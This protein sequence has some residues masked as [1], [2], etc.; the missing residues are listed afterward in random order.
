MA[1]FSDIDRQL[2][3]QC[4]NRKLDAKALRNLIPTELERLVTKVERRGNALYDPR[5][6]DTELAEFLLDLHGPDLLRSR[7]VREK[8]V[9]SASDQELQRLYNYNN[10]IPIRGRRSAERE[11][12]SRKWTAGKSWARFFVKVLGLAPVLAGTLGDSAAPQYEDVEPWVPLPPL[13]DFQTKLARNVLRVIAAGPGKN[14]GILSLPTGAGKT[15]TAVEAIVDAIWDNQLCWRFVL[16]VAQSDE[17]CEQAVEAFREVWTN[18]AVHFVYKNRG[19]RARPLRIFR[20]W[21][22]RSVPDPGEDGIIIAS[23][24]KLQV[25][26][27]AKD[28]Q[29]SG[30]LEGIGTVIVDEAHH[31]IAPSYSEVFRALNLSS[32]DNSARSMLGLTATPYR[33]SEVETARLSAR[34]Y[35][36]LL[37]PNWADPIQKLRDD[38]ILAKMSIEQIDTGQTFRLNEHERELLER[39]HDL[40]D[41]ALARIGNN[42][43][44]NGLILEKLLQLPNDPMNWAVLLF[45]CSVAHASAMA[46]LL[47]RAGR[48]ASVVTGDTP[49]SLRRRRIEQF[50]AGG[51]Q[52]LCN[53]GVLTTGFDAPK[54]RV[55]VI[56]RPTASV[57]LYEQMVGRG[58]R[59][60]KNGGKEECLV[61]DMVDLI[62]R[63]GGQ[64]SYRRYAELWARRP[65]IADLLLRS[66]E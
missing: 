32:R 34:F 36:K 11:V 27:S 10:S 64:M 3:V 33:G 66:D 13:H 15:R 26:V 20:L 38:G 37:A 43:D 1:D 52:F 22:G 54:V 35:R 9:A 25:L 49:R 7:E 24:Q 17:L 45:G 19:S 48:S 56:A 53:Y 14:R 65:R 8:L 40:P 12:V 29:L 6:P 23:I 60:P 30:L 21:S 2:C 51:L 39:F 16:W 47:R 4:L 57:L 58:M 46:L 44:R 63:F 62:P 50:R 42:R 18:R 5:L 41:S 28:E 61:I 31:A 55:V 59:G